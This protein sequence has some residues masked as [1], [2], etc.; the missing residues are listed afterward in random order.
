MRARDHSDFQGSPASGEGK[1][2][3]R[4]TSPAIPRPGCAVSERDWCWA[5]SR[6]PEAEMQVSAS[7]L[8][9]TRWS[10]LM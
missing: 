4:E 3:T 7:R 10:L 6:L 8:A 2:A 9:V 5:K 1:P